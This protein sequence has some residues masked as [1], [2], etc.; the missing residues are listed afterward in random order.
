MEQLLD[1]F[2]Q[3]AVYDALSLLEQVKACFA[4]DPDLTAEFLDLF[5]RFSRGEIVDIPA[6]V[7]RAYALLQGH[8][9]LIQRF[10]TYNPF[11]RRPAQHE[12]EPVRDDPP[13]RPKRER[14]HPAAAASVDADCAGAMRFLERVKLADAG[15]YDRVLALL[16][17]VRS[18]VKLDANQIYDRAREIFGPAHSRLLRGFTE[19]LPTGRDF[20]RRRAPKK[21]PPEEHRAPAPK[22]KAPAAGTAMIRVDVA[23]K[24]KPRVDER[25]TTNQRASPAVDAPKSGDKFSKFR[26]AWEFETT[27]T[28][29]VVTMRRT[30]KAL[31]ELKPKKKSREEAEPAKEPP[32]EIKPSPGHHVRPRTFEE[33]YPSREC[34]EVLQEMYG[35]MLVPMREALED[36]ARTELALK[37]IK[38]RLKKL[39]EV[40]VKITRERRD[41]ARV[42]RRMAELVIDQVVL[43]RGRTERAAAR[44]PDGPCE[45]PAGMSETKI[46]MDQD[47][48]KQLLVPV[49]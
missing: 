36:G 46:D 1:S 48:R 39:E 6:V 2:P 30:K 40:A 38:R 23:G 32:E 35:D 42:E 8:P 37:T 22:R 24:K 27:Y 9:D 5:A 10:D 26:E 45:S 17:H 44:N 16:F 7:A 4:P 3:P 41:P 15:F 33:L 31:Q 18:E 34:R 20:L 47:L 49:M 11:L 28:K 12:A 29:L 43:L 14:R 19:Y 25:K 13:K 21:E